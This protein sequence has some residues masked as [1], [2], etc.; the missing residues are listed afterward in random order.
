MRSVQEQASRSQP[1]SLQGA[2]HGRFPPP[3]WPYLVIL[4]CSS[5]ILLLSQSVQSLSCVQL[6]ATP[7][8]A[9]CQASLS[10]TNSRSL[11][12]PMPIESVMPSSHLILWHPHLLLPPIPPSIRGFPSLQ[13]SPNP[14][15]TSS[16]RASALTVSPSW[17]VLPPNIHMLI[18]SFPS[19]FYSK[20]ILSVRLS[21]VT[22]FKTVSLHSSKFPLPS[23]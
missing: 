13:C 19:D 23:W 21:L 9:A 15:S 3:L 7:W 22:L 11:P 6:F 4:L 16:L 18:L 14:F 12:K 10:I 17:N 1:A 2:L 5:H 20:I 8:T